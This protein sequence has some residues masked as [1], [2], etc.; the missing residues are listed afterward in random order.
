[1]KA[2]SK[3]QAIQTEELKEAR[4]TTLQE[5][6]IHI[7]NSKETKADQRSGFFKSSEQEHQSKEEE[8]DGDMT[9]QP[10]PGQLL[11]KAW[12]FCT[13]DWPPREY[14]YSK[15]LEKELLQKVDLMDWES[16]PDI[17]LKTKKQKVF[18]IPFHPG[19]F[20]DNQG[21]TWDLKP[22]EKCPTYQNLLGKSLWELLTLYATAMKSE[23]HKFKE[24]MSHLLKKDFERSVIGS[25]EAVKNSSLF[26][27]SPSF[28]FRTWWYWCCDWPLE[29]FKDDPQTELNELEWRVVNLHDWEKEPLEDNNEFVK[30][31]E[32]PLHPKVYQNGYESVLNCKPVKLAEKTKTLKSK[33]FTELME[34]YL[35]AM[36]A[37]IEEFIQDYAQF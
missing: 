7:D 31:F 37:K 22:R 11:G 33:S 35:K 14:D 17:D 13:P 20:Q 3:E 24:K 10:S 34:L 9:G 28:L 1:M 29:D 27:P 2:D 4:E 12:W 32:V 15:D 36:E 25:G 30:A 8:K 21:K 5:Q 18:E 16:V 6:D 26:S 23:L 19:L